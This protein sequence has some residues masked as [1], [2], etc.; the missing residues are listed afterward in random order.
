MIRHEALSK[1]TRRVQAPTSLAMGETVPAKLAVV[2]APT[3][4]AAAARS[5]SERDL[6]GQLQDRDA[7]R[8]KLHSALK[9]VL[10]H[11]AR[12]STPGPLG[13]RWEHWA[14]LATH[15][16][17]LEL[18]ATALADLLFGDVPTRVRR[19]HRSG[20]LLA[21]PKG[22]TRCDPWRV[23]ASS[24]AYR[25]RRSFECTALSSARPQ[26]PCSGASAAKW[27]SRESSAA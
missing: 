15:G 12:R 26:G 1:A 24:A 18:A 23:A 17:G 5:L 10:A 13:A 19:A 20:R 22:T 11:G 7:L 14:P 25:C 3:P 6:A 9:R 16:E 27:G 21:N 4:A 8:D 2:L